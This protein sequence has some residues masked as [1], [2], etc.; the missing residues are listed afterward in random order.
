MRYELDNDDWIN[1][2]NEEIDQIEKNNK[3]TFVQRPKYR[4]VIATK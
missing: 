3:W 4:Y 1:L 2:M